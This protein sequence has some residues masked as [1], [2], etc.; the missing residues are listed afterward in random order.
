MNMNIKRNMNKSVRAMICAGWVILA[1]AAGNSM[2]WTLYFSMGNCG[3][4]G[5]GYQRCD[6]YHNYSVCQYRSYEVRECAARHYIINDCDNVGYGRRRASVANYLYSSAEFAPLRVNGTRS[7]YS[8][9]IIISSR[10]LHERICSYRQPVVGCSESRNY[11]Y[12][13][14]NC[15]I[16]Y[17]Q[18]VPEYR[19]RHYFEHRTKCGNY[20]YRYRYH[21]HKCCH[22]HY[23]WNYI[24]SCLP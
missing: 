12:K 1:V 17:S 21:R 5:N 9:E 11:R 10:N 24:W 6:N 15:D 19:Y 2:G 20:E 16:G 4:W 8:Q 14:H 18:Y 7:R 22:G 13:Y 3:I 23:S